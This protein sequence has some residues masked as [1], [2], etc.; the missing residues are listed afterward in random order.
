MHQGGGQPVSKD[1]SDVWLVVAGVIHTDAFRLC[2]S[3]R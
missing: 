3:A 2:R 1:S